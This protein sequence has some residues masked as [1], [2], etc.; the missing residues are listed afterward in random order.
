MPEEIGLPV[1]SKKPKHFIVRM[2][3]TPTL[4]GNNEAV[5]YNDCGLFETTISTFFVR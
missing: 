5:P 2:V 3:D 1:S 4:H